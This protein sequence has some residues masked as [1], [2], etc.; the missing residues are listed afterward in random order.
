MSE[1]SYSINPIGLSKKWTRE[2]V[3]LNTT[4]HFKEIY[5]LVFPEKELRD[6]GPN[7]HIHVS[8]S[9]LYISST[10]LPIFLQHAQ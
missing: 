3:P 1:S 7:Y 9:D 4:M 6:L 5:I 10:G 8:L 2:S